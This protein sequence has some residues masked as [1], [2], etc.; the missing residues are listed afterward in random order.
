[1]KLA[2]CK[3]SI[4]SV[5]CKLVYITVLIKQTT[6]IDFVPSSPSALNSNLIVTAIQT[7]RE[8]ITEIDGA[9]IHTA[10]VW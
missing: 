6:A 1:M 3:R 8:E 9:A 4:E 5:A 10:I 7:E 2:A